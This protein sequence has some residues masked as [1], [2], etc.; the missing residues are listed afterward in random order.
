MSRDRST[1]FSPLE[2]LVLV[3]E[4]VTSI[5]AKTE[6]HVVVCLPRTHQREGFCVI[7]AHSSRDVVINKAALVSG[8]ATTEPLL[9]FSRW[10]PDVRDG[11]LALPAWDAR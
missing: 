8:N 2:P 5:S 7:G 4:D 11:L 3:R 9:E 1:K 10:D 6:R